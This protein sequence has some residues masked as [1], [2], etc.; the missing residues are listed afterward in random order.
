MHN[1]KLVLE[2][3]TE[4]YGSAFGSETIQTGEV[5]IQTGMTGYQEVLSDPAHADHIVVMS[6]PLIG[7]YG[8]NHDDFESINPAVKGLI[9]R[10]KC[11][12]PSNFRS[13]ESLASYT[14]VNKIPAIEGI[15]TRQLTRHI[16]QHGSMKGIIVP[17][18]MEKNEAISYMSSSSE[19]FSSVRSLSTVKPYVV[20]GRGKRIVLIDLGLK[21]GILRSLTKRHCHVTVVPY[22]YAT[23]DI[24]RLQADGVIISNGPGLIKDIP[25]VVQ[26]I[27]SIKDTTPLFGI[28]LG[29]LAIALACGAKVEKL[30]AGRYVT[31]LPVIDVEKKITHF[32][33]MH[34]TEKVI[35]SSIEGKLLEITQRVSEDGSIAGLRHRLLPICSVQY[36]PES[37]PGPEESS[38]LFD[39]FLTSC[40]K[41]HSL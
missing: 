35:E 36:N 28:G 29:H 7:N 27:Q 33:S 26:M 16:R 3:G 21:H 18:T 8:L 32:T 25:S 11:N 14:K 34:Q 9:V 24:A 38:Y 17:S 19:E 31:G 37:A 41:K 10:E 40:T 5:V 6:Y 20:P 1:A 30:A 2:D 4:F 39:E 12:H 23:E 13:T 15:D 22:N